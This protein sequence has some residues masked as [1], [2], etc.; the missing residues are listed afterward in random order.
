MTALVVALCFFTAPFL[1]PLFLSVPSAATA[2]ALIIVGILMCSSLDEIDWNDISKAI[3]S[4]LTIIMMPL[5]FSIA[6]GLAFGF[7][8]YVLLAV[9][10]GKRKEVHWFM[11]ILAAL[12]VVYF[13]VN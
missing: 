4:I 7:I 8:S 9:L 11:Y 2:P 1:S 13:T 6:S 3:P 5:S 10:T 12:F